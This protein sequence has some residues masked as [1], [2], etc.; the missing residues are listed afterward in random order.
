MPSTRVGAFLPAPPVDLPDRCEFEFGPR[1][2]P[3]KDRGAALAGVYAVLSR[4]FESG[5]P[6]ASERHGD[7]QP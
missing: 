5:D 1:I 4:R 7:H 2:V 6:R 3:P